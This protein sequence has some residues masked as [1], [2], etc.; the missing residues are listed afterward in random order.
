MTLD[1]LRDTL[2]GSG[3]NLTGTLPVAE[4]DGLVADPWR[5]ERVLPGCRLQ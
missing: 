4:Y 3:L 2:A 5:A 1:A